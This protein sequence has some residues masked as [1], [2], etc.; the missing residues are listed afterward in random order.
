MNDHTQ[1]KYRGVRI[2]IHTCAAGHDIHAFSFSCNGT[3][4]RYGG[5]SQPRKR[6]RKCFA[7]TDFKLVAELRK[8][9]NLFLWPGR[10]VGAFGHL[11]VSP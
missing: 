10:H 9:L 4:Y 5:S 1:K 11:E 6:M 2:I 3:R 8:R 7:S